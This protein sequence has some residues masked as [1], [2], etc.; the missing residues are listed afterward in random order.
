MG[1]KLCR[2]GRAKFY[3]NWGIMRTKIWW[4]PNTESRE[5][6]LRIEKLELSLGLEDNLEFEEYKLE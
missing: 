2:C 5:R 1:Y 3:E 4:E 6:A